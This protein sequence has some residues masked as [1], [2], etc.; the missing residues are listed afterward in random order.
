MRRTVP[1]ALAL[2]ALL[3]TLNASAQD[4]EGVA[5]TVYSNPGGVVQPQNRWNPSLGR[6]VQETPGFAIVKDRRK[7]ALQQG[8]QTYSFTDVASRIDATT[9]HFRSL[10]DPAGTT[11]LEQNYEYDLVDANRMLEKH[12]DHGITATLSDGTQVS[13]TLL[14]FDGAQIVVRDRTG[15]VRIVRRGDNLKDLS[16]A[17]LPEGLITRP[18]L[19]WDVLAKTAGDHLVDVAYETKGMG[20]SADYTAVLGKN[21]TTVDL[22]A[23]V[24]IRNQSG[25]TYK[26]ARLKLVAGDIHRAPAPGLAGPRAPMRARSGAMEM[27][28]GGFEEKSFFEYHLYTLGR[29]TTLPDRSMKQIELFDPATAVPCRKI[30]VYDGAKGMNWWH[31]SSGNVNRSWL[32][33]SNKKTDVYVEFENEKKAGLGIPLPAGRIRVHKRDDADGDMELVGEDRIDHTPRDETVRLLL[34]QAFDVVGERVQTDFIYNRG[35]NEVIE[36]FEIRVRNH[37]D[38]AIEVK[39]SERMYRWSQW[40]ITKKSHDYEKLDYR[41][42]AIPVKV[43]ARGETKVTY[44]VRYWW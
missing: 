21:D 34:G 24:T 39:I 31:G 29:A 10:T 44:T 4:D 25:A 9:V 36:S 33:A 38:E 19:K 42:I 11:V 8:R 35:R 20:W 2:A 22:S 7:V 18:T 26:D 15:G 30:F 27:D 6:W 12:I 28:A 13:G 43:P 17:A 3:P 14:S 1:A 37:K 16:F 41:I 40:E 5:V 32:P 23:W